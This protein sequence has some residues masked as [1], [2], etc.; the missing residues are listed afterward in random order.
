MAAVGLG[1][2]A[3]ANSGMNPDDAAVEGFRV[4][5]R[6]AAVLSIGTLILATTLRAT[7]APDA[8]DAEGELTGPSGAEAP[9]A[10]RAGVAPAGTEPADTEPADTDIE[11]RAQAGS[12]TK[13]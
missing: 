7:P 2:A 4:A 11:D 1:T 6:L 5:F 9:D 13:S 8:D 3:A 10:E 12:G